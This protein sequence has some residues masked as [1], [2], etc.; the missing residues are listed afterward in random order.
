MTVGHLIKHC[1]FIP[2]NIR[3]RLIFLKDQKSS[4]APD[5]SSE[6]DKMEDQTSQPDIEIKTEDSELTSLSAE[7]LKT[8]ITDFSLQQDTKKVTE[9]V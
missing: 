5:H 1:T 6:Q 4:Q 3:Q 8:S 2:D 7:T 9:F